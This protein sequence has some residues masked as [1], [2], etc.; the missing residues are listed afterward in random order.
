MRAC[1][2]GEGWGRF[3]VQR[4]YAMSFSE[5]YCIVIVLPLCIACEARAEMVWVV[6]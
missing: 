6:E 5:S 2:R 1:V 3:G 4:L